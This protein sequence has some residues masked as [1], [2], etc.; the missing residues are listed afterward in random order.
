MKV[1]YS[2]QFRFPLPEGHRFSL[3]KYGLLREAVEAA[4]LVSR[5]D[6]LVA[7]PATDT[8]ILRAHDQGYLERVK[9]GQLTP[10]EVRRI[11]LPW[12]PEL[13][14][15]ARRSTGGTIAACRAALVHGVAGNLGGGTH[16]AFWDHGQGYCLF[17]DV[18]IAARAMQAEGRVRRVVVLDTDAHQ[19]N[20]TAALAAGDPTVY[21]FSIH[22][23]QSFPL[24]KVRSDLDIGL[25]DGTGDQDYL[26]AL[27]DGVRRAMDWADS[28]RAQAE[29]VL[30]I[31]LAGAD[32][33]EGDLLGGLA[34]SK[35]GLAERDRMVLEN[36]CRAGLPVA[37]VMA[38]GYARRVADTVDIHLQTVR[39]AAE[40]ADTLGERSEL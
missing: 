33:Y 6:L 10:R 13:V 15:R 2:D 22:S 35:R 5:G 30:A 26:E 25:E 14:E 27:E 34:L 40:M 39:I 37:M 7:D 17:N 32:P 31:F 19:G 3:E 28:D 11:G 38:G 4:R 12:S 9:A 24:F 29:P 8:Q 1:F 23:E 20:G 16:H 18:I 21:T 36:C